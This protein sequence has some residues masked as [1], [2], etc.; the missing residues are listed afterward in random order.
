MKLGFTATREGM[1]QRQKDYVVAFLI[2]FRPTEAHHGLCV[3]GD[4]EFHALVRE[5]SPNTRIIGH[6]PKINDLVPEGLTWSCDEV[7]KPKAYL[8]RN[9]DIVD[10]TDEM[11]ACPKEKKEVL[12]SGTW[13]TIRYAKKIGK[14]VTVIYGEN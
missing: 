1:S 3:G 14:E 9:H 2:E 12:R 5:H 13:A 11:L 4:E 10:E 8:T 7:R 6:P